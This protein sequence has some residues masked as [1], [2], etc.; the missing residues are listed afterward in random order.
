MSEDFIHIMNRPAERERETSINVKLSRPLSPLTNE[1]KYMI[2]KHFPFLCN[3]LRKKK[4]SR[5]ARDSG[6]GFLF[7]YISPCTT[8]RF[9]QVHNLKPSGAREITGKLFTKIN[10]QY[11]VSR[12]LFRFSMQNKQG[13]RADVDNNI[14]IFF[15]PFTFITLAGL[16]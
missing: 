9:H 11:K 6:G 14:T 13:R 3:L 4:S 12:T 1:D 15:F 5:I 7:L 8:N 16:S 10:I 2:I